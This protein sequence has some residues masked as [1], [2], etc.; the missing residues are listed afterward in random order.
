MKEPGFV[1]EMK[2][3]IS[4]FEISMFDIKSKITKNVSLF[5]ERPSEY[6]DRLGI[7][8]TS[9]VT[10]NHKKEL[11]QY[12]TP[13]PVADFMAAFYKS[14]KEKLRILDPGCGIGILSIS[15]IENIVDNNKRIKTIELVAFETDI[16]VLPIAEECL[17]YLSSWLKVKG[18]EFTY[19]LC[20]NDF[21]LH[22]SNVLNNQIN[23]NESYDV[24]IAN[25]PYFKLP[26]N[27]ERAIAAKSVIYGQSNIYSIFLLIA[28]K[29][30]SE[31]G[32]LIFIT[33]RSFCSGSYFRLFRELFLSI[34]DLNKIHL[35]KSRKDAFKRDNVLQENIIIVAN[36]KNISKIST[37]KNSSAKK[38][39]VIISYSNGMEDL[40]KNSFKEYPINELINLKSYQKIIHLPSS[41]TDEQIIKIFKKWKGSLSSYDLEI[42]TGRVVDFRS[43]EFITST[44][45]K[46]SVPLIWLHNV[47]S[48]KLSW[49]LNKGYKG[50]LKEQYIINNKLSLSR[51][52]PNKNYVLLR[53]FSAKDDNRRL[54]A[55]PYFRNS[56][57][58]LPM[59]GIENHLNYIY[60]KS[61]ELE[62][63]E[64]IGISAL[65]N[66]RLFD[67]Y[68]RTFNGNINVSATELR[69][70]PL[71]D[72]NLIKILGQKIIEKTNKKEFFNLDTLVF[73]IFKL[74]IDL[75]KIYG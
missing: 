8:Y 66:S 19:F 73:E 70:F 67:I 54:I 20:K 12:F 43:E 47:E 35:F 72:F 63:K 39:T 25:P 75:S 29:L 26:K 50:K 53:R 7:E 45:S 16:N 49:P 6:A 65:L 68:F 11:G 14:S 32:Q 46:S 34:V 13:L 18:I 40:N 61:F 27:D 1:F 38:N 23:P 62:E 5:S 44:K 37:S 41:D 59:L 30:L 33:P 17:I 69:D 51:L 57:P 28:A 3:K 48:M 21:I 4:F 42:S 71:P 56:N 52:V 24:V 58:N 36:K 2:S 9:K 15:L 60:H 64:A 55:A 31:K 22:N 10:S 74:P